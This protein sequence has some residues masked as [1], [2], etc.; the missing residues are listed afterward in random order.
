MSL[1]P[2]TPPRST[3]PRPVCRGPHNLFL[4]PPNT[5]PHNADPPN[6]VPHNAGP[7]SPDPDPPGLART[8]GPRTDLPSPA[9]GHPMPPRCLPL[10]AHTIGPAPHPRSPPRAPRAPPAPPARPSQPIWPSWP[11]AVAVT[12]WSV[13]PQ[14][15]SSCQVRHYFPIIKSVWKDLNFLSTK[16]RT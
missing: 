1:R 12:R 10:P 11:A 8:A 9:P 2:T 15:S 13:E 4:A 6:T 5:V 7:P 3:T 14:T 16:D